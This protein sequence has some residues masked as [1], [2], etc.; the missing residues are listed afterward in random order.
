M[1]K[2]CRNGGRKPSSK[3]DICGRPKAERA[4]V[5]RGVSG[6]QIYGTPARKPARK[7]IDGQYNGSPGVMCC[8]PG[9]FRAV[10]MS[11]DFLSD[12]KSRA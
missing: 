2:M 8:D 7:K 4:V 3:N 10:W 1:C 9:S 12:T 5:D 11:R 6:G